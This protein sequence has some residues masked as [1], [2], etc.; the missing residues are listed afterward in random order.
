M[1]N[2]L[3]TLFFASGFFFLSAQNISVIKEQAQHYAAFG[4]QNDSFWDALRIT[5]GMPA[6]ATSTPRAMQTCTLNKRVFGWH[7]YWVG[8]VYTNYQWNLMSDLCYFDYSISPATG[9]NTNAS[10][11]YSTSAAVTAA[12]ANGV[13]THICATL[14]SSHSTFLASTSAQQTFITNIINLLHARGGK[15]VNLDFEGMST[16]NA[17]AYTAFVINL[18]NQLHAAIP[19]SEVSMALYAV[20]WGGVFDIASLTPYTDLFIIMGYDYY[21]SGSTTAGPED[22]LYDFETSYNYTLTKSITYYLKQGMPA[23]K[24]LLGLPYYGREWETVGSAAPS[25][26]TGNYT[27]TKTFNVVKANANG[28]YSNP[29][30]EPNSTSTFYP[31]QVAATWRQCWCDDAYAMRK[32]FD[33]VNQRNLGG[34]GIWALGYD[35]GYMDFWNAI[36]DKFSNCATVACSDTLY[37]MGG[38]ARNY[39]DAENYYTTISPTGASSVSLAFSQFDVELNYDTLWIYDGASTTSPLIGAYTGTNSPGTV[40]STGPSITIRFKSDNSTN[41][42]GFTAIWNCTSDHIAPTTQITTPPGWITQ[43][44]NATFTDADNVNGSGILKSFYQVSD[45]N[46]T[47]WSANTQEGFYNDDFNQQIINPLFTTATGT[48][49]AN[50]SGALEQSDQ[51]QNNTNIYAPLTQNLSDRYLYHFNGMISGTGNNRRAG[52]HFFCDNASLPNRGNNYFVWFRA[53]QSVCEFYKVT[54][55]VFSLMYSV[56]MTVNVSTWYDYKV[57]YDRITGEMEVF[58]NDVFI[59]SWT[60]PSPIANGNYVSFRSGNCDWQVDN[61][62]VFRSRYS[63]AATQINVGNC[64]ACDL[65]YE[66]TAISSSAG[67]I[68]SIN[69]DNAHN[70]STISQALLNVDWTAPIMPGI[71]LDGTVFDIDTTFNLTQLQANWSAAIDTNSGV[72][73]Y[74]FAVGTTSGDSDVVGWTNNFMLQNITTPLTLTAGQW[75]YFSVRSW[76]N[77]GLVSGNI[78]SDGQVAELPTGISDVENNF[79]MTA[80]P[81]PANE[82]IWVRI[83]SPV[84]MSGK[85]SVTD[86]SGKII[87]EQPVK[88]SQPGVAVLPI[89][90]GTL[91]AGVYFIHLQSDTQNTTIKIIHQ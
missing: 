76:N 51:A 41:R 53:D 6:I 78:P 74:W 13:N 38:P 48:W 71:I 1:K 16:S 32:R 54:N 29:Q 60:D 21:W 27:A 91:A 2:F 86:A 63:N 40:F 8:N 68:R 81:N 14:F 17:A 80:Y 66:N 39:Y 43:N 15:G 61:F 3:F 58:Q 28:Y 7:P 36:G 79:P 47:N 26:T 65:R 90:F 12:I 59:G 25:A 75:Y 46:G 9:N 49:T 77:A 35:D 62:Q 52:I 30:M 55:D 50:V 19:G 56:P 22:P 88:F 83:N 45:F 44:F 69:I 31:Y 85:L 73:N 18:S 11:A 72:A 64:A 82:K 67:S 34:I 84:E 20:D 89:E 10:F 42:P 5:E 4:Q 57:T 24:L 33:I 87:S 23:N 37:D 70:F